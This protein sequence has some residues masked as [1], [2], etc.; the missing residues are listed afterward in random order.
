MI[1]L[2]DSFPTDVKYEALVYVLHNLIK[3]RLLNLYI[4]ENSLIRIT[5]EYII[6]WNKYSTQTSELTFDN[7]SVLVSV[8]LSIHSLL[9]L[10]KLRK[11][12]SN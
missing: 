7:Y 9:F 12:T 8:L 11:L 1:L 5:G 10:Q 2:L 3:N 6:R 4:Q